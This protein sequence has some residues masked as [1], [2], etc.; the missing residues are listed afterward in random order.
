MRSRRGGEGLGD[1]NRF[2]EADDAD[3][4][5]RPG[6]VGEEVRVERGQ[7]E[8]RQTRGHRADHRDA[9][10]R[11]REEDRCGDGGGDG[12]DGRSLGGDV[13]GAR[14]HADAGE[15]RLQP[16]AGGE[17]EAEGRHAE[18]ERRRV[19]VAEVGVQARQHLRQGVATARDAEDVPR[20]GERDQ[21]GRGGDEARDHRVAE[22]V[23]EEAEPQHSHGDEHQAGE[24]GERGRRGH[25]RLGRRQVELGDRRRRHQRDHRYGADREGPAGAEDGVGDERQDAGVEP[26]DRRQPCEHR[27]GERLRHQH[28]RHDHRR[29]QVVGQ[30]AEAVAPAPVEDRQVPCQAAEAPVRAAGVWSGHRGASPLALDHCLNDPLISKS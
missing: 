13:G 24:E 27:V 22:E 23:G 9:G 20:L 14:G 8:R 26:G 1:R 11:Q 2:D 15:Q 17:E 30:R 5:R 29:E 16:A 10:V 7:A 6:E 21:Q 25:A 4:E 18:D 3:Q 28:D 12:E 19:G